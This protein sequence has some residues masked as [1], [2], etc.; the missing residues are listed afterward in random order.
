MSKREEAVCWIG[1]LRQQTIDAENEVMR[2]RT[3]VRTQKQY[4]KA[5]AKELDRKSEVRDTLGSLQDDD[6]VYSYKNEYR[7]MIASLRSNK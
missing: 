6:T 3:E 4:I 5:L 1:E 2:L 7:E